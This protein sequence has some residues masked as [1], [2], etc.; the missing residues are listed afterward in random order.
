MK[1]NINTSV[2]LLIY[3]EEYNMHEQKQIE[4]MNEWMNEWINEWMNEWMNEQRKK[5]F[6]ERLLNEWINERQN[7]ERVNWGWNSF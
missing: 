3:K 5:M 6:F 4:W 1:G 7:G 2:S